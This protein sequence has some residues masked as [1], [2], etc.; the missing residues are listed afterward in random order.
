[1]IDDD[2]YIIK[3]KADP[4]EHLQYICI[5]PQQSQEILTDKPSLTWIYTEISQLVKQKLNVCLCVT[6]MRQFHNL[7]QNP[8]LLTVSK[9]RHK[10]YGNYAD[11]FL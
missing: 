10:K 1:M 7:I 2:Q 6:D 4:R 5:M 11:E 3:M 9:S 8:I